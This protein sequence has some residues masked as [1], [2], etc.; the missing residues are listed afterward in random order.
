MAGIDSISQASALRAVQ[1]AP[2]CP[3]G[4]GFLDLPNVF[5][6]L[7]ESGIIGVVARFAALFVKAQAVLEMIFQ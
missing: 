2:Y 6:H 7:V 1:A 4:P 3:T 5:I